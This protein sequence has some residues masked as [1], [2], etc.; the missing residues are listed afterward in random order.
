MRPFEKYYV[1]D[2]CRRMKSF[3]E[4]AVKKT[5]DDKLTELEKAYSQ[6]QRD[7][8]FLITEELEEV[9]RRESEKEQ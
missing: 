6:G 7:I 4:M 3:Y 2:L 5:R 1:S 8:L 9:I